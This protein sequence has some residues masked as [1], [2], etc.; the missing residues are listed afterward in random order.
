MRLI[1]VVMVALVALA[2]CSSGGDKK[3]ETFTSTATT[4]P[5]TTVGAG[6]PKATTRGGATT[7]GPTTTRP[8]DVALTSFQTP[9]GNIGCQADSSVTRCDIKERTWAPPPKPAG[10][11]F[12]WGQGIEMSGSDNP[13]FVCAGD[14]A[15]DTTATV[16]TYGQRTRQGSTICDSEQA[17]L[18]CTNTATGHG[19]FMSRDSYRIF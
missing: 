17:G 14:T 15:L 4:A 6:A 1:A 2:G 8:P 7:T 10:C 3:G 13:T 5:E 18:T 16:L 9:S 12:D 11:D 19:L